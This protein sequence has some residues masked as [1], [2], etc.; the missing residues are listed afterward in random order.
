[1]R[2]PQ[3]LRLLVAFGFSAAALV[4]PAFRQPSPRRPPENKP[5][6]LRPLPAGATANDSGPV[7]IE[8]LDDLASRPMH[9]AVDAGCRPGE[10]KILVTD[11]VFP[12]GVTFPRGIPWA[13][14]LSSLFVNQEKKIQVVDRDLFWN[15]HC[16]GRRRIGRR[17][18]SHP[19]RQRRTLRSQRGSSQN[20]G[21]LEVQTG[22]A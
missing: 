3:T 7:E 10:C 11:F 18:Q 19:N 6:V 17:G 16:G 2:C 13:G 20:N 15:C 5:L 4:G 8:H 9:H 1:M 12:D 21:H 14:D 22:H